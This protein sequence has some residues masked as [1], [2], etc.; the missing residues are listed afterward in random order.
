M[1]FSKYFTFEEA[2]RTNH[3]DLLKANQDEAKTKLDAGIKFA[4]E[5]LD[6]IRENL[7]YPMM[8]NSFYR[9]PTLNAKVGGSTRSQHMAFQ[10]WDGNF[11][12]FESDDMKM[13]ILGAIWSLIKT[14]KVKVG[15]LLIERGCIH[16]SGP[17]DLNRDGEVAYYNVAT[18]RKEGIISGGLK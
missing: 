4:R 13:F 8:T 3:T 18:K 15:Q 6:P 14:G 1:E 2:T 11:K 16:I 5:V 7:G 17:R 10:A 9:G 12:G